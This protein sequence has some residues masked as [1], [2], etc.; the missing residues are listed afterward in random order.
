VDSRVQDCGRFLPVVSIGVNDRAIDGFLR[1]LESKIN[2]CAVV[3]GQGR[4]V[5]TLS[6]SNLR[7][8]TQEKLKYI[9]LPVL[10]FLPTMTGARAETPLTCRANDNLLLT[11]K[12]IVRTATRR[13][14]VVDD[15]YRPI[16]YLSMGLIINYIVT[17]PCKHF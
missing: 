7:G 14:W 5:A 16:G 4:I 15:Y 6:A 11:M 9:L 3:D 10:Q 2:A 17:K 1:I 13:G 12:R 8:L